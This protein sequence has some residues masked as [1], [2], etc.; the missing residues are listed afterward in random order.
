[1]SLDLPPVL[2]I[3]KNKIASVSPW[4]A[5]LEITL[6]DATKL[7]IVHNT[8]D[9]VFDGNTYIA[10]PFQIEIPKTSA[11]GELPSWT[12]RISNA[13]LALQ[14]YLEEQ[15]GCVGASVILRFVNAA[16]LAE[17][18]TELETSLQ[19]IS[20]KADSE[21]ITF[22]LAMPSPLRKRFPL[23]RYIAEHCMW[24][25]KGAE[26]GYSGAVAECKK[27]LTFCRSLN[28]SSRF[29]GKIGMANRMIR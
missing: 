28:N 26:C 21:W 10:F 17:N 27:T 23:Y 13:T 18:Y 5:L 29:S 24:I 9:I 1:M 7:Y 14:F 16:Y 4:L 6:T 25:F 8:E 12:L 19:V 2:I 11:T 20:S 22:V 15:D 3:E